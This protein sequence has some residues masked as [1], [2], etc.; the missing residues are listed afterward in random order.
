MTTIT[1][2][3]VR[4]DLVLPQEAINI[5]NLDKSKEST[6]L[7]QA[8]FSHLHCCLF[9]SKFYIMLVDTFDFPQCSRHR[10]SHSSKV[11]A[12]LQ[13]KES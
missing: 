11:R 10:A 6:L 9:F 7:F 13:T 5:S 4:W 1:W 3:S 12:I 2:I 8:I